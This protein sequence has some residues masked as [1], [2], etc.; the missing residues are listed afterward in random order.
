MKIVLT[1]HGSLCKGVLESFSMIAGDSHLL[2]A[3]PL[4]PDDTGQYK[5]KLRGFLTEHQNENVLILCDIMG[6]TPYNESYLAFLEKPEKIRVVSGLNLG[7]LL[8]TVFA[9]ENDT[10]LDNLVSIAKEAGHRSIKE[11]GQDTSEQNQDQD[12]I[13]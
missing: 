5:E 8:E 9:A 4:S 13:F 1:S 2:I 12:I 6:G 11:A 10:N 3:L 7:M